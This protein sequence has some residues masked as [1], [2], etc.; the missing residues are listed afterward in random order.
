MAYGLKP[1]RHGGGGAVRLNSFGQY[2]ILSGYATNLFRGDPVK[3]TADGTL[4]RDTAGSTMTVGVFWGVSYTDSSTGEVKYS[5]YWPASTAAT[6]IVA[7]VYD[8]PQIVFEVEADQDTTAITASDIGEYADL[9][10][11]TGSLVNKVS[12]V[13]LDSNTI[14]TSIAQCMLLAPRTS[15]GLFATT[16]INV[17]VIFAEHAL[18][19][20]PTATG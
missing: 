4:I 15:D 2:T 16:V 1:A 19:Q 8:D 14:G 18:R 20:M 13:S 11:A 9:I 12:G 7:Y 3:R 17:E 10:V 6:A 5:P